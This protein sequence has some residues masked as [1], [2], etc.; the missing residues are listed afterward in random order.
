[1]KIFNFLLGQCGCGNTKDQY[2][3]ILISKYFNDKKIV[4]ASAGYYHSACLSENGL[5]FTF[6]GGAEGYY[7]KK[8]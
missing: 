7:L 2:S 3:P 8:I 5:I 1:M 4:D 6:G